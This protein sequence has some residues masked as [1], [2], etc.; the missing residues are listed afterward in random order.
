MN[1]LIGTLFSAWTVVVCVLFVGIS[2]W[3]FG[4]ARKAGYEGAARIPLD[5]DD[6]V[7]IEVKDHG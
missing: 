6:E 2:W 3:V 7:S 5:D 1:E 4:S